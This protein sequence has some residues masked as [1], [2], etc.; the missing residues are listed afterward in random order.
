MRPSNEL[1]LQ[2]DFNPKIKTYIKLVVGVIMLITIIGI[3]ILIIWL[4]GLGNYVGR[5]YYENLQCQ[6]TTRHLEFKKGVFF[7]VEKTIPL[8]NIQDLTFIENPILSMLGLKILKVETAG[9]S[10]PQ[11]TDMK[12]VGIVDA[13]KFK[14][15][16]LDQREILQTQGQSTAAN[17][18]VGDSTSETVELLKE[19][20]DLLKGN[21]EVGS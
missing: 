10:N 2:A 11:G 12:L 14:A 5:R 8:E 15:K 21:Q 4:L 18:E 6:L 19:I 9:N 13:E 3:P 1:I 20:R 7:K 16:V 17:S